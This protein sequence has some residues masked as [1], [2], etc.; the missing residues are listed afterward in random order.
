MDNSF[1]KTKVESPRTAN[2]QVW[3]EIVEHDITAPVKTVPTIMNRRIGIA[4]IKQ[5]GTDLP[6][7]SCQPRL[8]APAAPRED[9]AGSAKR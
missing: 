4:A 8:G 6:Q 3:W 7:G 1:Q 5:A 2:Q 9:R